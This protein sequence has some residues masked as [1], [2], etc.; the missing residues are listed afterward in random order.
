MLKHTIEDNL[1]QAMREGNEVTR[2]T[3]RMLLSSI[4]NKEIELEK[5]D[6]GLTDEEIL[7]VIA[8]E[9]KQRKDAIIGYVQGNRQDLADVEEGEIKILAGYL[10]P[11]ISDEELQQ[12]VQKG[13]Q[14]ANATSE[15]DFGNVMRAVVPLLKGKASGDR[16]SAVLRKELQQNG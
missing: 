14:D 1:K 4:R 5:K 13:I 8:S 7:G 6:S 3:L 11:E 12:I 16:I 9:V 15:K 10:P 2:S